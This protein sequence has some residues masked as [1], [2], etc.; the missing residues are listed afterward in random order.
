MKVATSKIRLAILLITGLLVAAL[1]RPTMHQIMLIQE[2]QKA[3]VN[4]A[5]PE[6]TV[7]MDPAQALGIMPGPGK[8]GTASK[9][10]ERGSED[11]GSKE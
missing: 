3:K 7:S 10:S 2:S 4:V 8:L 11:V 9:N 1:A 5:P 6:K